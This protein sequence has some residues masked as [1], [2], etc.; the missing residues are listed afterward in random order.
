MKKRE[1]L[2]EGWGCG[3]LEAVLRDIYLDSSSS[4]IFMFILCHFMFMVNQHLSTVA[5]YCKGLTA[6]LIKLVLK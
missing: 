2:D 1:S 4:M 5:P 3:R 6:A